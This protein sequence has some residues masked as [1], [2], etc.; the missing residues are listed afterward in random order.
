MIFWKIFKGLGLIKQIGSVAI[1]A[2]LVLF[3]LVLKKCSKTKKAKAH[4][5]KE[6]NIKRE[7]EK[8]TKKQ[9]EVYDDNRIEEQEVVEVVEERKES[10]PEKKPPTDEELKKVR[11]KVLDNFRGGLPQ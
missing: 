11:G 1:V 6:T 5:V 3:P 7:E 10:E 4:A 2:S 8:K 9:V